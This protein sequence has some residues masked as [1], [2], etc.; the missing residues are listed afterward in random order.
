MGCAHSAHHDGDSQPIGH[1]GSGVFDRGA[2]RCALA[3]RF[4]K[5]CVPGPSMPISYE[6]ASEVKRSRCK[7]GRT[8]LFSHLPCRFRIGCTYDIHT[9]IQLRDLRDGFEKSH[10]LVCHSMRECGTHRHQ[11]EYRSGQRKRCASLLRRGSRTGLHQPLVGVGVLSTQ[12][13]FSGNFNGPDRDGLMK[14]VSPSART[15]VNDARRD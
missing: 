4:L 5:W 9:G 13:G 7:S 10:A 1:R 8:R 11:M 2:R 14:R 3:T 12:A 15:R 6:V